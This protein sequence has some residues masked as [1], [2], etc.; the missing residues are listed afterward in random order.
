MEGWP[1]L[2]S[3][4]WRAHD[5]HRVWRDALQSRFPSSFVSPNASEPPEALV[6][7]GARM[8]LCGLL[9]GFVFCGPARLYAV[10]PS[11]LR[12]KIWITA[13]GNS[14]LESSEPLRPP[15]GMSAPHST[16]SSRCCLMNQSRE[17]R[18]S[19]NGPPKLSRHSPTLV[20]PERS[21][22]SGTCSACIRK[23]FELRHHG[24]SW[25][26]RMRDYADVLSDLERFA[27]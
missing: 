9:A 21:G 6:F 2:F 16:S 8:L 5:K 1:A 18:V 13:F 17:L 14:C 10:L 7:R 24:V 25:N 23:P 22:T 27:E 3:V 19:K 26:F 20:Y 15:L 11:A 4:I 12:R